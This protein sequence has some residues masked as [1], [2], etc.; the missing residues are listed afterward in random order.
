MNDPL[1]IPRDPAQPDR[2]CPCGA[3][4]DSDGARRCRK[5]RAR[6]SWHRRHARRARDQRRRPGIPPQRRRPGQ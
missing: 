6:L 3:L 1:E 5:C 2:R 4:A